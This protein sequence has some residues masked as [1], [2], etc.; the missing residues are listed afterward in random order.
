MKALAM[1][2]ELIDVFDDVFG[3]RRGK[4][5][6][7]AESAV[8]ELGAALAPSHDF[9]PV[10]EGGSFF[11]GLIFSRE[12]TIGDFAVVEDGF[13]FLRAGVDADGETWERAASRAA[14]DFLARKIRCAERRAGISRHWLDVNVIEGAARFEGV[15]EQ[16]VQ[17]H[18]ASNAQRAR[19]GGLLKI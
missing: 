18:S 5:T 6:T 16:N 7:V 17:K 14:C 13:Y 12:I 4:E 10:Q 8:A 15:D 9:V 11:D 19:A 1:L 2:D 3:K